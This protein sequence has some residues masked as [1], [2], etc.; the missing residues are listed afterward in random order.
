MKVKEL[1]SENHKTVKKEIEVDTNKWKDI[2]CS[3]SGR[4]NTVKI[5]IL[6]KALYRFNAISTKV[7]HRTR[8]KSFKICMDT[9][10]SLNSQNNLKKA[11][12]RWRSHAT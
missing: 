6:P 11:E 1:F 8:T 12:Q 5:T 4:I 9:Q 2:P 3:W 10:Q 7:F